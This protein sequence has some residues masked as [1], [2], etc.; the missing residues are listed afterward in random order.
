MNF[1]LFGKT[2]LVVNL[3]FRLFWAIHS[4]S[5]KFHIPES[6]FEH[7]SADFVRSP[8]T[9]STEVPAQA[10]CP[11]SP[12]RDGKKEAT[13][14]ALP[15]GAGRRDDG[16]G[17]HRFFWAGGGGLSVGQSRCPGNTSIEFCCFSLAWHLRKVGVR[18]VFFSFFFP[19]FFLKKNLT[20]R[21]ALEVHAQ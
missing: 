9:R 3:K 18:L 2:I 5:E 4:G 20:C 7:A 19:F 14:R 8:Q 13:S 11:A 10:G 15:R 6:T 21:A 16:K 1:K 17:S 12:S